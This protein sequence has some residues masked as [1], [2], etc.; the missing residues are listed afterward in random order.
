MRCNVEGVSGEVQSKV[1]NPSCT[2]ALH[3]KYAL[4]VRVEE[5]SLSLSFVV[6]GQR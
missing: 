1:G 2:K 5:Q 3:G 6:K 4:R